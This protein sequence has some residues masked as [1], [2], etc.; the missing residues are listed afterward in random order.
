MNSFS[1]RSHLLF[2]ISVYQHNLYT[3]EARKAKITL[4]DLAGTE[5]LSRVGSEGKIL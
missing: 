4:V 5:K 1:S 2:I 3:G